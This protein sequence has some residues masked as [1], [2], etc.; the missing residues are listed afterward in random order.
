MACAVD[1]RIDM[2]KP[3]LVGP[4][5]LPR[6][7]L[8]AFTGEHSKEEPANIT[9]LPVV[10]VS[11]I[12]SRI[13]SPIDVASAVVASRTVWSVAQTTSFRL[14]LHSRPRRSLYGARGRATWAQTVI[15]GI[16]RTM[17]TT[18]EL[19]LSGC[20][21]SDINVGQLLFDLPNLECLILDDCQ[22]LTSYAVGVLSKSVMT[23]LRA[24]SLQRCLRLGPSAGETLLTATTVGSSRLQTLLLS[25]LERVGL[26][27][28]NLLPESTGRSISNYT[29]L[30]K[31]VISN[32]PRSSL[33]ILALTNCRNIGPSQ[34]TMIA[35]ACPNLEIW[36]LG[37]SAHGLYM[38][39][40]TEVNLD[41]GPPALIQAAQLLPKLRILEITFFSKPVLDKVRAQISPGVHVWDYREKN[42]VAAAAN[43]VAHL[44]GCGI[45]MVGKARAVRDWCDWYLEGTHTD[46]PLD[47]ES[48]VEYTGESC[49][50]I[51]HSCDILAKD[52]LLALKAGVNCT[53]DRGKTPLH[54]AA[55][56]GDINR[57]ARLLFIGASAGEMKDCYGD[58]ALI[59]AA[60]SGYAEVCKLL[61]R[62]GADV[63]TRSA[64]GETPLYLAAF[65]EYRAALEVMLAH[66]LEKGIDWQADHMYGSDIFST[67]DDSL[68]GFFASED[69]LGK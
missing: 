25:H 4:L 7:L 26:L 6:E 23:G 49:I 15:A 36:M 19:D 13:S 29:K 67:S 65:H 10:L 55:F 58:T 32:E 42:S 48:T 35:E 44:K 39:R 62:E 27:Q 24:L 12:L 21:I 40:N 46:L 8:G 43:W 11:D 37:G 30:V 9:H 50:D 5:E 63:L 60:R 68:L 31:D 47:E 56:W 45:P 59:E 64:D 3:S 28:D 34:L 54:F 38:K 14:K 61:L 41:T 18:E 2:N 51:L 20:P 33:R 53:G 57:V 52:I 1:L 69:V 17:S 22:K 66:C 16:R